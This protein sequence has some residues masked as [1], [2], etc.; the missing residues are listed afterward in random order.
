MKKLQT[1]YRFLALLLA[2]VMVAMAGLGNWTPSVAEAAEE[3]EPGE[4]TLTVIGDTSH[5]AGAHDKY[6]YWMKNVS[7]GKESLNGTDGGVYYDGDPVSVLYPQIKSALA[8]AGIT[9][10]G[11]DMMTLTPDDVYSYKGT[12]DVNA[13][14]KN[15]VTLSNGTN[16]SW[17][18]IV[19]FGP[20]FYDE[21]YMTD[22]D[23]SQ[24]I[25]NGSG[26]KGRI[27]YYWQ[28]A[29]VTDSRISTDG[30]NYLLY[31]TE[32]IEAID[33][34]QDTTKVSEISVKEGESVSLTAARIAP[35]GSTHI[36][37]P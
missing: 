2:A 4:I 13:M 15:G 14:T 33:F 31:D 32:S 21:T 27:I 12:G 25:M 3:E 7:L 22:D 6:R 29:G 11:L 36:T 8:E 9:A 35:P 18:K 28:D 16:G 24:T 17:K 5:G 26:V 37:S 20:G 30:N 34:Y 10:D 19:Y 23:W 1:K